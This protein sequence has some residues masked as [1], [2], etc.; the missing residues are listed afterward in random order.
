MLYRSNGAINGDNNNNVTIKYFY[1]ILKYLLWFGNDRIY[2]LIDPI[3][4]ID[5]AMKRYEFTCFRIVYI[6]K[7]DGIV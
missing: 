1:D 2:W 5:T 6:I 4:K 3:L 7:F